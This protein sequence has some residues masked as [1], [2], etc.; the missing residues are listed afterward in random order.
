MECLDLKVLEF[1]PNFY[2]REPEQCGWAWPV[3]AGKIKVKLYVRY[4]IPENTLH[5]KMHLRVAAEKTYPNHFFIGRKDFH[6]I[7]DDNP[8]NV[9]VIK[10]RTVETT[11]EYY[12]IGG[13]FKGEDYRK[14]GW[15]SWNFVFSTDCKGPIKT[16]ELSAEWHA[17][18]ECKFVQY[19]IK[20][21]EPAPPAPEPTPSKALKYLV[22]VPVIAI[23]V[24]LL[25]LKGVRR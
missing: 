22:F 1:V 21:L 2:L 9:P 11:I 17:Q 15:R 20:G 18:P 25:A 4:L 6:T 10:E 14:S 23:P 3:I 16:I 24:L 13:S 5:D 12:D 7:V 8:K 19:K